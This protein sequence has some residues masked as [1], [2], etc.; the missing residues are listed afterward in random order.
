MAS[1]ATINREASV[2][3]HAFNL[4]VKA[5]WLSRVSHIPKLDEAPPRQGFVEPDEFLMLHE[6]L[7]NYL[8]IRFDFSI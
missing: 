2:L 5:G 8:K 4:M 7:S 6:A 3:R 1:N